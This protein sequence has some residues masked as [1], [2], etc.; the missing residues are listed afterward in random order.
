MSEPR[1]VIPEVVVV[2]GHDGMVLWRDADGNL[3]TPELAQEFADERNRE[4]KPQHQLWVVRQL[5]ELPD[6]DTSYRPFSER[7]EGS[8]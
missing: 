8:A 3:F 1:Y 6:E 4:M 2:D 7:E 5:T